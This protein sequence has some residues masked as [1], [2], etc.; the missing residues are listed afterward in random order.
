MLQR[1]ST[2]RDLEKAFLLEREKFAGL[3]KPCA[4]FTANKGREHSGI[5]RL[6][7]NGPDMEQSWA[8]FDLLAAAA[9]DALGLPPL[10][11][12][13]AKEF[14]ARWRRKKTIPQGLSAVHESTRAWLDFLRT[15]WVRRRREEFECNSFGDIWGAS[16]SQCKAL[17]RDCKIASYRELEDP[18]ISE[19]VRKLRISDAVP[20]SV[21]VNL[22]T[23]PDKEAEQERLRK[24]RCEFVEPLLKAKRWTRGKWVTEAG[25][26]KN[27]VYDYLHGRRKLSAENRK[28]MADALGITPFQL[29]E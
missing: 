13:T 11:H 29:P 26:G 9:I 18:A 15:D 14:D 23:P 27:S 1:V 4:L 20:N 25:V 16:A 7:P 22:L 3:E 19:Q 21:G 2:F 24:I 8:E 10:R 6:L 12:P 17:A 28:A 5:W